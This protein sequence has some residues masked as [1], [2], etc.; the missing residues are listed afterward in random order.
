MAWSSPW[1]Q[2]R[3]RAEGTPLSDGLLPNDL[4]FPPFERLFHE[5]GLP[6]AIRTDNGVPFASPHGLFQLSKLSVWWLRL[7]ISIER[8]RPGH[9][10]Q[11]GRHERMHLTLKKEATRP[12]GVNFL[13]QQAKFDAFLEEFNLERPHEAL[14]MKC[15]AEVYSASCRPY[16]GIPDPHYP[17]HDRTVVVTSCGRICLYNNEDQP[18]PIPRR[19]GGRSQ[20]S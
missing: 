5:R 1:G 3:S 14:A 10:Q 6:R 18:Q 9:P 16:L 15:P 20:R 19:P 8:I 13:Q 17:F 11:N 4:W 12:A 2:R 7:G